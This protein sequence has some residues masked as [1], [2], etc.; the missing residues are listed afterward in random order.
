MYI[1]Y[2]ILLQIF[3]IMNTRKQAI[4]HS[5]L[6]GCD[7]FFHAKQEWYKMV[8]CWYFEILMTACSTVQDVIYVWNISI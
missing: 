8:N 1:I 6:K 7:D 2:D 3:T 4:V 5:E